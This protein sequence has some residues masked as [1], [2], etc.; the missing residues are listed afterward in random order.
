[1]AAFTGW[2][3]RQKGIILDGC[4]GPGGWSWG[5]KYYLG[6]RD[7]G[8]EWDDAARATRKAAKLATR[9]ADVST[10]SLRPFLGRVWGLI[11]SP[12][13]TKLSAA[14]SGIGRRY[15][16]LLADGIRRM[17]RGED[18][19]EEIREA[20]FPGALEEQR[21]RDAKRP[22]GKRRSEEE[23]VQAARDDAFVTSLMLEPAR[24]LHALLSAVDPEVPF[25]WAAFEQV[26][27]AE[28][29]WQVYAE[30]L[31]RLGWSVVVGVLD[32]ADYGGGQERPRAIL[33]ASSVRKV[34]LPA[35]THGRVWGEDLF[36]GSTLPRVT[37]AQALGWS[38]TQ[39]PAPTV[40]G[41]GVATGGAEPFGNGSRR[42]MRAAMDDPRHWAWKRPAHTVSGTVGHVGGKQADG[43]LNLEPEEGAVLQTFPRWFPFHGT[44]GQRSRQIGDAMPPLLAAHVVSAASGVP[45]LQE[46]LAQAA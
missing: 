34:S 31:R 18:C 8:I 28:P 7:L 23:L 5:I 22:A 39:R 41:G 45:F 4:A 36:G 40:T 20:I 12:P 26:P 24:Y 32:L 42:A 1:M 2:A 30:E 15:I 33:L 35:K 29:M 46:A 21:K 37:M 14:G 10:F 38:Y 11:F 17:F 3:P 43:H 9:K 27:A 13:C 44:K 19:R 6:L 25:E 16:G